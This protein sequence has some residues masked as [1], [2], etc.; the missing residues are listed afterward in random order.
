MTS[1]AAK[2]SIKL[3]R[4]DIGT[5]DVSAGHAAPRTEVQRSA[6]HLHE[7]IRRSGHSATLSARR[8]TI[9]HL[10]HPDESFAIA[11]PSRN[12]P[13][14]PNAAAPPSVRHPS[15]EARESMLPKIHFSSCTLSREGACVSVHYCNSTM[16]FISRR[17]EGSMLTLAH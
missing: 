10:L 6:A 11:D 9:F 3:Q 13:Q 12:H 1:C 15:C 4:R 2:L 7:S 17:C 5:N 14:H 8:P 16:C